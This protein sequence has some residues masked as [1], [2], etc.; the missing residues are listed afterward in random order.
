MIDKDLLDIEKC[1]ED[2]LFN[3]NGDLPFHLMLSAALAFFAGF[4][5]LGCA[6]GLPSK[7][8][9]LRLVPL[10]WLIPVG[11]FVGYGIYMIRKWRLI[12]KTQFSVAEDTF[13]GAE[14]IMRK[15]YGKYRALREPI[16]HH[17]EIH[18]SEHGMYKTDM[19]HATWSKKGNRMNCSALVRGSETG[20][21]FYLLLDE[22]VKKGQTPKIVLA[23]PCK[24]FVWQGENA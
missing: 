14:A 15:P 16:L 10:L 13:C 11:Y 4:M 6:L 7:G 9:T 21:K 23:Y 20:D 19:T 2:L 24:Y 1:R 3:M 17:W 5:H 22:R 8:W 18:F 12:T